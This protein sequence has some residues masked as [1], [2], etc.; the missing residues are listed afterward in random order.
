[1][2]HLKKRSNESL[3]TERCEQLL[4]LNTFR[5]QRPISRETVDVYVQ[6][7]KAGYFRP[8]EIAIA[9]CG[10]TEILVNGQHTL[11]AAIEAGCSLEASLQYFACE[12]E[13]DLC[14]LFSTFDAHRGRTMCQIVRYAK[15]TTPNSQLREL[16][17][18]A[19]FIAAGALGHLKDDKKPSFGK[20]KVSKAYKVSL[21]DKYPDDVIFISKWAVSDPKL[22]R[23]PVATAMMATHRIS[24]ELALEFWTGVI[25]GSMLSP[26]S[27]KYQLR[28]YLINTVGNNSGGWQGLFNCYNVCIAWWNAW[29]ENVPRKSV[30]AASIKEALEP[31]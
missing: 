3:T 16:P 13:S 14:R 27:A 1:M 23:V 5:G 19:L 25:G 12:Q 4:K 11:S 22:V 20:R 26:D 15:F 31:R 28:K 29:R 2:Y 18:R 17:Q 10:G 9:K 21:L 24:H 30:K 8:V 6:E 7:M